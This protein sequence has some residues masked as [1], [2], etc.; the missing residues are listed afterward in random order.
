MSERINAL[1]GKLFH[2][3]AAGSFL[4]IQTLLIDSLHKLFLFLLQ[5]LFLLISLS[6]AGSQLRMRRFKCFS[7]FFLE[8]LLLFFCQF[9]FRHCLPPS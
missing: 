6:A 2:L 8:T 4:V 3:L 5:F 1:A 9:F 7:S